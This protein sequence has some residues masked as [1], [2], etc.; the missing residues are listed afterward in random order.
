MEHL[1]AWQT[2][3]F[4][5]VEDMRLD[6]YLCDA[7]VGTRSE[8]KKILKKEPVYINGNPEKDP[9]FQV[10]EEDEIVFRKEM[11]SRE[12]FFYYLFHKPAGCVCAAVDHVHDTVFKYIPMN[13]K[14]DLSTVGRLDLDTEGLLLVTNDGIFHHAMTSPKREVPKLYYAEV[15]GT[16][17]EEDIVKFA[18]GLDIG[19]DKPAKPAKLEI[20]SSGDTSVG[21]VTVTE[22]RFHEVKRLFL[23][24]GK[25]VTYLK[26]LSMGDFQ[27][28]EALKPGEYRKFN[29]KE[30]N[31]VKKYKS[32]TI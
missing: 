12:E 31:Y 3:A 32:G 6:K 10:K 30:M 15:T 14:K 11:L 23:A 16:L 21:L 1:F 4:S 29:E 25:E 7:G 28:D 5:F 17:I 2:D 9:G 27:L 18:S 22:G 20:V 13:R 8:V 19:D 26:R 24:C